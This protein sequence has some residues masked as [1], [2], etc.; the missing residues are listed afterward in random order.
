[1]GGPTIGYQIFNGSTVATQ[2]H[3]ILPC[4]VPTVRYECHCP[5]NG[6]VLCNHSPFPIPPDPRVLKE[7]EVPPEEYPRLSKGLLQYCTVRPVVGFVSLIT[8]TSAPPQAPDLSRY[9][10][11]TYALVSC[12]VIAELRFLLILPYVRNQSISNNQDSMISQISILTLIALRNTIEWCS[13]VL[14][15]KNMLIS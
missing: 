14:Y 2:L 5:G 4:I 3:S 6:V 9:L 12:F 11:I 1:M 13:Y 10:T 15:S 7:S 8:S